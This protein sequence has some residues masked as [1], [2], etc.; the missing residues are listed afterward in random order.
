M[1]GQIEE[2]SRM[3]EVLDFL[4]G[5]ESQVSATDQ[6]EN[7][8]VGLSR[9]LRAD[10]SKVTAHETF[11]TNL[12]P[13]QYCFAVCRKKYLLLLHLSGNK[14]QT[15]QIFFFV[16]DKISFLKLIYPSTQDRK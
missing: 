3:V 4:M 2:T 16:L 7:M 8:V 14:T 11:Q 5:Y 6:P 10:I 9:R 1:C 12:L 15:S 13:T